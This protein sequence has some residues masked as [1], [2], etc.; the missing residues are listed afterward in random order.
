MRASDATPC[1][2]VFARFAPRKNISTMLFFE[3]EKFQE[4]NNKKQIP[5]CAG[6][7]VRG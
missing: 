7:L 3:K 1:F 6:E 2:L 5:G 4:C